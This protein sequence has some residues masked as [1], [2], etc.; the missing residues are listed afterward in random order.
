MTE[1]QQ[2]FMFQ[3]SVSQSCLTLCSPMDGSTPGFPVHHQLSELAETHVHQ[4]GDTIQPFNSLL[5]PS[6]L[7]SVLP[8]IRVFSNKSALRI[9]WPT[10]GASASPSVFKMNIQDL[11][12]LELTV[13]ISWQSMGLSRVFFS[14]T[15]QRHQFFDAQPSLWSSAHIHT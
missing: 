7:P 2:I 1:Q 10:F 3:R 12:P 9:R 8:S 13:L 11:F 5:S 15:I 14:T 4:V 6:V